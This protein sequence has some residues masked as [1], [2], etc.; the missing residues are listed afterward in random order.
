MTILDLSGF[1]DS[2]AADCEA[3]FARMKLRMDAFESYS[4]VGNPRG[5]GF[6]PAMYRT[7]DML[8]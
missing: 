5:L 1:F 4:C 6:I 7:R 8:Q 2:C 3:S